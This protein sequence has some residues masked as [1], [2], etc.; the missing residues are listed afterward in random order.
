MPLHCLVVAESVDAAA[1]VVASATATVMV[2][3]MATN[4]VVDK[5]ARMV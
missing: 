5:V 4:V 1:A 3:T 2:T